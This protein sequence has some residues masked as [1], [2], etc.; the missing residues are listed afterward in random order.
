MGRLVPQLKQMLLV[1]QSYQRYTIE[2]DIQLFPGHFGKD[3]RAGKQMKQGRS[4]HGVFDIG[5]GLE[6][7]GSGAASVPDALALC[8]I[9]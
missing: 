1:P 6:R 4:F 7:G 8:E 5:G 3:R 2:Q 9:H